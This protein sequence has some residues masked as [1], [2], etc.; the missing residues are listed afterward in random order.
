VA[1]PVLVAVSAALGA[2]AGLVALPAPSTV[3]LQLVTA[4]AALCVV[5]LTALHAGLTGSAAVV[6]LALYLVAGL[7]RVTSQIAVLVPIGPDTGTPALDR[8]CL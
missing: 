2:L 4:V 6:A 3:V 8:Q 5:P 7:P 1:T